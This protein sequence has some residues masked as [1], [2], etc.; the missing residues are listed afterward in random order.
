MARWPWV[1]RGMHLEVLAAKNEVIHQL[2]R[3]VAS[4]EELIKNPAPVEVKVD[5][6][7]NVPPPFVRRIREKKPDDSLETPV[8]PVD[9][10]T[11]NDNDPVQMA[12]L[13]AEEFGRRLSPHELSEWLRRTKSHI[14]QVRLEKLKVAAEKSTETAIPPNLRASEPVPSYIPT[15]IRAAIEDAERVN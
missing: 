11:V 9:W 10:A 15:H 8:A 2:Q 3:H 12:R 7:Q 4:L 14:K 13:A 6:V 1:S 5:F